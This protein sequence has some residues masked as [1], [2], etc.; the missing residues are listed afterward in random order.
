[1]HTGPVQVGEDMSQGAT[2]QNENGPCPDC[3]L[4]YV[5]GYA[6]NERQHRRV[7][8]ESVN[9]HRTK[10]PDGFRP[11]THGFPISEQKRVEAAAS[12]ALWE[13]KYDFS[14]F[15]A[16]KKDAEEQKTIA[17]LYIKRGRVC[18]LLVS[19][20]RECKHTAS[21]NSFHPDSFHFW[22]PTEV[23]GV[24]AHSRRV[25]EMIWVLK[26]NR[27]QGVAKELVQALAAHCEIKLGD[28]AHMIPFRQDAL[29]LWK[30]LKLS[31]IYVV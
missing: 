26:K 24:E 3:G 7:H 30:A 1:G 10:L 27:R 13:T 17:M 29:H 11:V 4:Q 21:L 6:P 15:T 8:D 19:R 31:T 18:G 5:R 22:R 2:P 25:V 20:Q 14:S 23:T 9:G 12:T 28:L 16:Y